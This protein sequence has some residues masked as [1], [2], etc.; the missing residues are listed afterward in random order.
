MDRL[1]V[2][3]TCWLVAGVSESNAQCAAQADLDAWDLLDPAGHHTF[4]LVNSTKSSPRDCLKATAQGNPVKPNAQ[5][6]LSFKIE[7]RWAA[8]NWEFVTNGPKMS[9][10]LGDRH[11]EAT[12]VYGDDTCHV[13]VLGSGNIEY[14]K[15]SDSSNPNPCCQRVFDEKRGDRAF[16]EPQT[17]GC[18]GA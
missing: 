9:A 12:I 16:T 15:R 11:E 17:K 13:K 14:W 3:L 2:I 5:V 7:E 18:T 10:T 4:L 6:E 8:T 1:A